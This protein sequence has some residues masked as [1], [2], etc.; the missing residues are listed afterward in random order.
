MQTILLKPA[1]HVTASR[2]TNNTYSL[3]EHYDEHYDDGGGDIDGGGD[4][5]GGGV[6]DDDDDN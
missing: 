4:N 2:S 6:A 3:S 1:I 5:D